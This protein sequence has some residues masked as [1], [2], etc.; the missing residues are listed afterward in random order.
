MN[1]DREGKKKKKK[2]EREDGERG[3][4]GYVCFSIITDP[5]LG[6]HVVV[7]RKEKGKRERETGKHIMGTLL[8]PWTSLIP[9]T[10]KHESL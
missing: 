1:K 9:T 4:C 6:L 2:K 5:V 8:S 3:C 7:M 10:H